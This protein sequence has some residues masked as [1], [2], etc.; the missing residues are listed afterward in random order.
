DGG[1]DGWSK[2]KEE[3]HGEHKP[4]GGVHAGGG[5]LAMRV[6]QDGGEDGWSKEKEEGHGEHKPHGGVHAGG[7]GLAQTGRSMTAGSALLLGGLGVGA[8]ML[9]RRQAAGAAA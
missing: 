4:H 9:R 3:G 5:G 6:A 8:Y 1:E 2:E 7:G